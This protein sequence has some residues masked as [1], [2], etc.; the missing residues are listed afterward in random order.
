MPPRCRLGRFEPKQDPKQSSQGPTC[1][2]PGEP[3]PGRGSRLPRPSP[4]GA[5]PRP[6]L[7]TPSGPQVLPWHWA[8][9]GAGELLGSVAR[10]KMRGPSGGREA[11]PLQG[12]ESRTLG[13][14]PDISRVQHVA[15]RE[16]CGRAHGCAGGAPLLTGNQPAPA[17]TKAISWRPPP[18]SSI[19]K[20]G[21]LYGWKNRGIFTV[22]VTGRR[23][24]RVCRHGGQFLAPLRH[25]SEPHGV[26]GPLIGGC[27]SPAGVKGWCGHAP[28]ERGHLGPERAPGKIPSPDPLAPEAS[29]DS[30]SGPVP[31]HR[32]PNSPQVNAI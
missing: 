28:G 13:N 17:R 31:A 12:E 18:C 9:V 5:E 23:G 29:P 21:P 26:R 25:V 32:G 15:R 4:H 6:G 1:V 16:A 20:E 27:M 3:F 22:V 11:F 8:S 19:R 14:W 24:L 10:G 2:P 7:D 30:C